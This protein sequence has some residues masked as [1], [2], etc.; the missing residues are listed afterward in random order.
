MSS[1]FYC[2]LLLRYQYHYCGITK[3]IFLLLLCLCVIYLRAQWSKSLVPRLL[4][5]YCLVALIFN[6][7]VL[8]F[9]ALSFVRTTEY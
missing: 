4:I 2:I 3:K 5:G 9:L 1:L 8:S 6:S 7:L